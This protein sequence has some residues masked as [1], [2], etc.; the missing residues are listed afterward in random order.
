MRHRHSLQ[1]L[2]MVASQSAGGDALVMVQG[3]LHVIQEKAS[4]DTET[5]PS[6]LSTRMKRERPQNKGKASS[7][8][9]KTHDQKGLAD[10]MAWERGDT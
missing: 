3:Q 6:G 2:T 5:S 9:H 1:V 4:P 8:E 10:P 7:T